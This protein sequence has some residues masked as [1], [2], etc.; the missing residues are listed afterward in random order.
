MLPLRQV[1]IYSQ[2]IRP[3]AVDPSASEGEWIGLV[4][5]LDFGSQSSSDAQIQ[6]LVEYLTSE[7]GGLEDQ[8]LSSRISR[9][10]I[11]G[12]SISA[13]K[14]SIVPATSTGDVFAVKKSVSRPSLH[15]TGIELVL[16][17]SGDT[18]RRQRP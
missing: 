4:S 12:N 5:G 10:I 3:V 1:L 16:S 17:Y 13:E 2:P 11:A 9:I 8:Q 7:S 14:D 18:A 15:Y 6:M